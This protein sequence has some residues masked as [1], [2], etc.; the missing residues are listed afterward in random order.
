MKALVVVLSWI[1]LV[2]LVLGIGALMGALV[3]W[4]Y[5]VAL[6]EP[7]GWPVL[8]WWQGWAVLVLTGLLFRSTRGAR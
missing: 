1:L 3:A 2:A 5:N 7:F 6:A 4:C 8:A